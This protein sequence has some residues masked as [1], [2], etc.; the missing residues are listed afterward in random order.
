MQVLL[1]SGC[2]GGVTLDLRGIA[3]GLKARDLDGKEVYTKRAQ[4]YNSSRARYGK[5]PIDKKRNKG[6]RRI[7]RQP[8]FH[9]LFQKI[10]ARPF[11]KAFARSLMEARTSLLKPPPYGAISRQAERPCQSKG[12]FS[13]KAAPPALW[14]ALVFTAYFRSSLGG[15]SSCSGTYRPFR[16][17][18][19]THSDS[20][21][22]ICPFTER[23]SSSAQAAMA[24]Y[25]LEEM[26]RGICFFD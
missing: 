20:R 3:H 26:R 11:S 8:L 7:L 21:Y 9:S 13:A 2:S 25:S 5:A 6:C 16:F 15:S 17:R 23:K 10:Q 14:G 19:R 18:W 12:V 22:S 24:S 4:D 1:P